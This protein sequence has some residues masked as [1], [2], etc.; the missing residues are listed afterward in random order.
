MRFLLRT[1]CLFGSLSRTGW[2]FVEIGSSTVSLSLHVGLRFRGTPSSFCDTAHIPWWLLQETKLVVPHDQVKLT[3]KQLDEDVTRCVCRFEPLWG[4][5]A[6]C[7][8]SA[9]PRTRALYD[10]HVLAW[11]FLPLLQVAN[12]GRP[13]F[14]V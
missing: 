10:N 14:P 6:G 12:C 13:E 7:A 2:A 8:T 3:A 1:A 9:S 11:E 5:F 4:V